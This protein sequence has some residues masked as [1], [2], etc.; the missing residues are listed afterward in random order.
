M[1]LHKI[2]FISLTDL[3]FVSKVKHHTQKYK[4]KLSS[5]VKFVAYVGDATEY[6]YT[7]L[8]AIRRIL[9]NNEFSCPKT[10]TKANEVCT[11]YCCASFCCVYVISQTC[12]MWMIKSASEANL[13]NFG[14]ISCHLTI[15]R[16]NDMYGSTVTSRER[17]DVVNHCQANSINT[18]KVHI[19]GPL[20]M[21]CTSD[22]QIPF[23][24]DQ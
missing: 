10:Y 1:S 2:A 3:S 11:W 23:A 13:T 7:S 19:T 21:E 18:L 14:K 24:K 17:H 8:P 16:I 20:W 5:D 22:R 6:H 15:K 9:P 12:S 4:K